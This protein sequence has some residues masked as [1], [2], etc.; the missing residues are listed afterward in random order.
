MAVRYLGDQMAE[1]YLAS[2]ADERAGAVL[3]ELTPERWLSVDYSKT[4]G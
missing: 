1:M 3:V 2:T 4:F